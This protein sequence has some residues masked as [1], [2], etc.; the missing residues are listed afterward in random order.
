MK[1]MTNNFDKLIAYIIG[2]TGITIHFIGILISSILDKTNQHIISYNTNII[3]SYVTALTIFLL[4]VTVCCFKKRYAL[5]SYLC[6]IIT[7]Y[8]SFPMIFVVTGNINTG[9]SHYFY[10]LAVYYGFTCKRYRQLLA[11]IPNLIWINI[12]FYLSFNK[13]FPPYSDISVTMTSYFISFDIAWVFVYVSCTLFYSILIN[14]SQKYKELATKDDLTALY[15]RRRLDNDLLNQNYKYGIMMDID[16]FKV[17]ND[18]YGHQAGDEALRMLGRIVLKHCSNEFKMYRYG[19]EEFFIVS[20][21]DFDTT[22]S[23]IREIYKDIQR[24]FSVLSHKITVSFGIS[25]H[26]SNDINAFIEEAD[27]QLYHAK[28]NGRNRVFFNCEE[29]DMTN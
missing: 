4:F 3:V 20:R 14:E 5:F 16:H 26:T 11:V 28:N 10:I 18:T 23:H 2:L 12:L 22:I 17:I 21:Y 19:G 8:I 24:N 1:D 29:L 7:G 25:E 27:S 15:N 6:C 9:F 13:A